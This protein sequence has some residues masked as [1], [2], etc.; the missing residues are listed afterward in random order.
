MPLIDLPL[1]KLREYRGRN[2]RPA[3][4]DAYWEAALAELAAT[5]PRPEL[6]PSPTVCSENMTTAPVRS[7]P[8]KT[9]AMVYATG[10]D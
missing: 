9:G 4:H 3:D 10:M 7:P 1:E 5:D 8:E 2:P 6:R